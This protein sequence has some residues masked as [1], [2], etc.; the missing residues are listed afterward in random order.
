MFLS[1]SFYTCFCS[2]VSFESAG[3]AQSLLQGLGRM[4]LLRKLS[5]VGCDLKDADFR[6]LTAHA[7]LYA[8]SA[9]SGLV[10]LE[11]LDL[12]GNYNVSGMRLLL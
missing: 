3:I 1:L 9:K 8:G 12:S 2:D 5:L 6:L 7:R 10:N 4:P 11:E